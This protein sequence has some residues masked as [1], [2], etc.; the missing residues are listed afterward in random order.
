MTSSSGPQ[1][2]PSPRQCEYFEIAGEN[3]WR[4]TEPAAWEILY[5]DKSW[6]PIG[7]SDR[8]LYA[9]NDCL[10]FLLDEEGIN[11]VKRVK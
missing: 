6:N 7:P 4:C 11:T 5:P 1:E 10:P 3:S 8:V 2:T 9:C